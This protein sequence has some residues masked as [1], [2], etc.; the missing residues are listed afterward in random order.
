MNGSRQYPERPIVGVGAVVVQDG[1]VLLVRRRYEPL[2]GRWSLPGG[3]VEVGE[4]LAC[5]VIREMHEETGL[6]VTVGPVIEVFDRIMRD[7]AE[8]VQYHFVL[9]DYLCWPAGGTLAAGSD[10]DDARFVDPRALAPYDL[11]DKAQSVIARA[12]ELSHLEHEHG[13][14]NGEP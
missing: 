4:T 3:T 13:T 14:R 7:A 2:A 1:Q 8:R 5:A 12:F 9:V 11:T 6:D 10:V